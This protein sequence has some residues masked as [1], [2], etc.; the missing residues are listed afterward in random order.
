MK[1]E[2]FCSCD[3]ANLVHSLSECDNPPPILSFSYWL[4]YS[5][6][7]NLTIF[8]VKTSCN[9]NYRV[10]EKKKVSWNYKFCKK[11]GLGT[12]VDGAG[13]MCSVQILAPNIGWMVPLALSTKFH[14]ILFP[15]LRATYSNRF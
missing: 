13:A 9:L 11:F 12:R 5:I 14:F 2:R 3:W 1:H 8:K 15:K 10:R 7:A 6:H 4:Y